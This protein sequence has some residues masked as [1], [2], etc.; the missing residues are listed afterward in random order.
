MCL[1]QATASSIAY[2]DTLVCS[3]MSSMAFATKALL[4]ATE[5]DFPECNTRMLH[6]RMRRLHASMVAN[7]HLSSG[8]VEKMRG[9]WRWRMCIRSSFDG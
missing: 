6:H 4:L 5:G 8:L 7:P 1:H 9:R 3:G 2:G